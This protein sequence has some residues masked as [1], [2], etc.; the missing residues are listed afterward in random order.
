MLRIWGRLSS[1]NVQKVTWVA[2]ECG[3]VFERIEAGMQFG[4]VDTPEYRTLNPNAAIPT[5]DD[6]GLILWES[7]AITRYIAAQYGAGTVWPTDPAKRALADLWMDWQT[8]TL[9][10]SMVPAF[11]GLIRTAPEKR[12]QAA[13]ATSIAKAEALIGLLDRHLQ[14]KPF[15]AG[16]DFSMGDIALGPVLHRWFHMPV[17][18]GPHPHVRRWYNAIANRPAARS[19]LILPVT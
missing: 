13:I 16:G 6:N 9:Y 15:V 5:I 7:N 8:T 10:P 4:V 12:D 1:I 18:S 17:E 3:L 2:G 14:D 19:S 11:L